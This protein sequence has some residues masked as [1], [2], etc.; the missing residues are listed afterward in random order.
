[1]GKLTTLRSRSAVVP[2][3]GSFPGTPA[4]TFIQSWGNARVQLL[5][6]TPPS[7][8]RPWGFWEGQQFPLRSSAL[9]REGARSRRQ[10]SADLP[11]ALLPPARGGCGWPSSWGSCLGPGGC[12]PGWERCRG[13]N[14]TLRGRPRLRSRPSR[15]RGGGGLGGWGSSSARSIWEGLK[16]EA[17]A[18]GMGSGVGSGV[19][20]PH[21]SALHSA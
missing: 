7:P 4:Q 12:R 17:Q 14:E 11:P 20:C 10:P 5:T 8:A 2:S 16:P 15:S 13:S 3:S 1:M 21:F 18:W 6:W 19:A 9:D